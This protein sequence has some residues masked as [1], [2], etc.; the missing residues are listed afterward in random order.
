MFIL[1]HIPKIIKSQIS[2]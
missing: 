2:L 1:L